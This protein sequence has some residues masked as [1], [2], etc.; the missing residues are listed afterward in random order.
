MLVGCERE[1]QQD[2]EILNNLEALKHAMATNQPSSPRWA[3]A[4]QRDIQFAIDRWNQDRIQIATKDETLT[5]EQAAAMREYESLN[6][7]LMRFRM[8]GRYMSGPMS[9]N[10][11]TGLPAGFAGDTNREAQYEALSARVEQAREPVASILERR[12][13]ETE[14]IRQQYTPA[15]LVA[16]FVGDRF[17]LVVDSSDAYSS[18]NSPVLYQKSPEVVDITEGVL[19]LFQEKTQ[20]MTTNTAPA[21]AQ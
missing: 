18:F 3:V 13:R 8:P 9:I 7:Q 1:D 2:R 15:K 21:P 11:V 20:A 4:R 16:E 6:N 19:K 14:K 12:N 10:P 17:D 5:P